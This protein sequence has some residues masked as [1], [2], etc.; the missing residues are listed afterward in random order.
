ME[1]R[2]LGGSGEQG[3]ACFAVARSGG[4]LLLDAGV[5][6]TPAA[7]AE[8]THPRFD[9][10]RGEVGAI[11][12]SHAHEDHAAALPLASWLTPDAVPIYATGDTIPAARAACRGWRATVER[13]GAEPPYDAAA[14][15]RL[16]FR[17]VRHGSSVATR[18]TFRCTFGAAGHVPGSSWILV[19]AGGRRLLYTGDW[20]AESALLRAPSFPRDVDAVLLD[21]SYGDQ[22]LRQEL[23]MA[24]LVQ[25]IEEV[26][27]R[28]GVVL[29]PVPRIGRGQELLLMLAERA[30]EL[31]TIWVDDAV[32]AGLAAYRDA[33]DLAPAGR[34]LLDGFD[35]G[36]VRAFTAADGVDLARPVVVIATD[37]ML[38][39]GPAV[40]LYRR[41]E[42]RADGLVILTGYQ[43]AGTLGRQLLERPA[44]SVRGCRAA[45][46]TWKVHPDLAETRA[47]LA[48]LN[49]WP[50]VFP[51]HAEPSR[52]EAVVTAVGALGYEARVLS[53]GECC[54][55]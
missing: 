8:H 55:I 53:V 37:G 24:R 45:L 38:T 34:R 52:G 9:L 13:T 5:K 41:L 27:G 26:A 28:D 42:A 3:R 12:L 4:V 32:L 36:N 40:A 23:Q 50:R 54:E 51:V 6:R 10:L 48:H 43:E 47:L 20:S 15:E 49:G 11:L 25:R 18:G 31:P 19:E 14:I 2:V 1:L 7:P 22:E 35:S 16:D 39:G 29:L 21:A 44:Q 46:I 33:E 17:P 30:Q